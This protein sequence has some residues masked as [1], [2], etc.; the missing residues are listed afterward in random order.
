M[1]LRFLIALLVFVGAFAAGLLGTYALI[2]RSSGQG[3]HAVPRPDAPGAISKREAPVV[4]E[5]VPSPRDAQAAEEPLALPQP[6]S[7]FVPPV[8]VKLGTLDAL[9]TEPAQ[10]PSWWSGLVGTRCVVLLAEVGFTSLS[11]RAG[12]LE[13]GER[14]DWG[15]RFGKARKVGSVRANQ[16][17]LVQLEALGYGADDTPNAALVTVLGAGKG[18][19]G[20]MSLQVEGKQVRLEPAPAEEATGAPR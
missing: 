17:A 10:D 8:D 7:E 15:A 19:R 11:V 16:G 4:T 6:P 13:D 2:S 3:I 14:I 1:T 12:S 5:P 18:V 20:V 9:P